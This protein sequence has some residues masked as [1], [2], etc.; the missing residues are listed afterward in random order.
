MTRPFAPLAAAA[1]LLLGSGSLLHVSAMEPND[2]APADPDIAAEQSHLQMVSSQMRST[3]T[4][5]GDLPAEL[6]QPSGPQ[7]HGLVN[8]AF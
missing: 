8:L 2:R 5:N 3:A 4:A 7:A 1:A 6:R